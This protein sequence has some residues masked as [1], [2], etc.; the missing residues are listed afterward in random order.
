MSGP[1]AL[2][3]LEIEIEVKKTRPQLEQ[4]DAEVC[5]LWTVGIIYPT[6]THPITIFGEDNREA[7]F[8]GIELSF[9]LLGSPTTFLGFHPKD[10]RQ[11]F[12]AQK[13]SGGNE[14]G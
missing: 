5:P 7:L 4:S 8:A 12:G 6:T 11:V 9:I 10:E 3:D 14:P 1:T 2:R 13:R